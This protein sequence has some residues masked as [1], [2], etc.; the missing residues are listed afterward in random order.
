MKTFIEELQGC[1][2]AI[3]YILQ[4]ATLPTPS[5]GADEVPISG[6]EKYRSNVLEEFM[7]QNI[8]S[9]TEKLKPLKSRPIRIVVVST[10]HVNCGLA[11]FARTIVNSI[12]SRFAK[13]VDWSVVQIEMHDKSLDTSEW[14]EAKLIA[15][16][17][18]WD[19]NQYY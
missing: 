12:N 15:T 1:D 18:K 3:E 11:Y 8:K 9:L 4:K 7:A 14:P 13:Y 16:V 17:D 2:E 19:A 10:W 6:R 5:C